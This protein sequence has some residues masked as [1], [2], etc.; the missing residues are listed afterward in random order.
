[1]RMSRRQWAAGLGVALLVP[2]LSLALA[3]PARVAGPRQDTAANQARTE[4]RTGT[5]ARTRDTLFALLQPVRL[6][7]CRLER[8]GEPHD[9]GYLLCANL[10]T[11]AQAAYSYGISG[12]DQWGCDV[13]TRL[14]VRLHQ[15]DCF[16]TTQPA[17]PTGDTV[18][19]AECVGG[20]ARTAD[21]R[22][23]DTIQNQL[24]KNGDSGKRIV[25]K[26]DVEGAEWDS[27]LA[28]PDHVLDQIEQI[29]VEFHGVNDEK[30]LEAVKRLTQFFHVAWLHANNHACEEG[31]RP[32]LSWAYEVLFVSKRIAEVDPARPPEGLAAR[33]PRNN[34]AAPDCQAE[35]L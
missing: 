32:F 26:I 35:G 13:S 2:A 25:L 15:Y 23:F 20:A 14:N 33:S 29:A 8:F 3:S 11:A 6:A 19:H 27:L 5:A 17:C 7:N 1:M 21:G 31:I 30:Y 24:T 4:A 12:Y 34:P 16:N 22:Q 9:G 18:F 10:L 28:T